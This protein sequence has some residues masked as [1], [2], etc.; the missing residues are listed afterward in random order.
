MASSYIIA[1]DHEVLVAGRVCSSH[2]DHA[3]GL[4]HGLIGGCNMYEYNKSWFMHVIVNTPTYS[5]HIRLQNDI[6]LIEVISLYIPPPMRFTG[7]LKYAC[8]RSHTRNSQ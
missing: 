2:H 4:G 5:P 1:A 6:V 3:L 7:D 8:S